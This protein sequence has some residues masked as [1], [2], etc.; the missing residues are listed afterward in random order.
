V[1]PV[2]FLWLPLVEK[3]IPLSRYISILAR[4]SPFEYGKDPLNR[5]L[6][7]CNYDCRAVHPVTSFIHEIAKLL[8]DNGLG[9]ATTT[10]FIGPQAEIPS[11][12]G[13]YTTLKQTGGY[14][15]DFS[16]N[17]EYQ[18]LG[19]QVIVTALDYD[20]GYARAKAIHALLN[21]PLTRDLVA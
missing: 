9:V 18:N 21:S 20:L 11:G 8:I 16:H 10:L 17:T 14:A 6:F 19:L 15:S 5:V 4:Q 1:A 7:S 12:S 2:A 13:P 3:L